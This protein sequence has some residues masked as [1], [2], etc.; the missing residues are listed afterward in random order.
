MV[1]S[2]RSK[3]GVKE[4]EQIFRK[5]SIGRWLVD[6][7]HDM[8][9]SKLVLLADKAIGGPLSNQLPYEEEVQPTHIVKACVNLGWSAKEAIYCVNQEGK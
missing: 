7:K 6:K 9:C 3:W 5:T 8:F 1:W 4:T 2:N